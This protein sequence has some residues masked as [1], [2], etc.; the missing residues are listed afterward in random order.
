LNGDS[1][2]RTY[3]IPIAF[4]NCGDKYQINSYQNNDGFVGRLFIYTTPTN[5]MQ[6]LTKTDQDLLVG[7]EDD[8]I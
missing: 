2:N 3:D 1:K 6:K 8:G 7:F 5:S 4:Y